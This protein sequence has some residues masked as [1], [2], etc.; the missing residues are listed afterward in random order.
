[1]LRGKGKLRRRRYGEGNDECTRQR[2]VLRGNMKVDEEW[3]TEGRKRNDKGE[4]LK[5][6]EDDDER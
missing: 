4:M 5:G 2:M 3:D 6:R 1:M